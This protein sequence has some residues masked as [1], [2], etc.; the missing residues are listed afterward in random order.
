MAQGAMKTPRS[1]G[2]CR[3][4]GEGWASDD[5]T[6][7]HRA[8]VAIAGAPRSFRLL[9]GTVRNAVNR[10]LNAQFYCVNLSVRAGSSY[11]RA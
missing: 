5:Q 6:T 7:L 1:K 11:A 8:D 3:R 9:N 10:A 2:R 4:S